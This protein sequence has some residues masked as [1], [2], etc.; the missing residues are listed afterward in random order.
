MLQSEITESSVTDVTKEG[1]I[2]AT[3]KALKL[4]CMLHSVT[5][6]IYKDVKKYFQERYA[7]GGACDS[8]ARRPGAASLTRCFR[9]ACG[10]RAGK[11]GGK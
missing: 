7:G 1:K 10:S 5:R 2:S 8:G 11:R 3:T 6:E 4:S 9:T